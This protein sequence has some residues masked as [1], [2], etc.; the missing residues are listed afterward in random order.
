MRQLL[1]VFALLFVALLFCGCART[2]YDV[3]FDKLDS[4]EAK[5]LRNKRLLTDWDVSELFPG[6]PQ[7]QALATA[8]GKGDVQKI[9]QLIDAGADPNASGVYGQTVPA[10][11]VLHPNEKG[12]RRLL[13]RGADPNRVWVDDSSPVENRCLP[14]S[15]LHYV[16]EYSYRI[17]PEY[18]KMCLE[19]GK[20]DPNLQLPVTGRPIS[21][22]L[23]TDQREAFAV[24]YNAGAQIDYRIDDLTATYSLIQAAA[25]IE[26]YE[27]VLFMLE[28][29]VDY[30]HS[31]NG[32]TKN[33]LDLM[34]SEIHRFSLPRSTNN[35][36]Y[37]YFW[38][39]VDYLEKHGVP[40]D[41]STDYKKCS[42]GGCAPIVRPSVLATTPVDYL[43]KVEDQD[44]W[45]H[46]FQL[47]ELFRF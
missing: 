28:R 35:N 29:G 12:F 33:L 2:E 22:A 46:R 11:L 9:D 3:L 43:K 30:T 1:P 38:R 17:G 31:G 37:M 34:Q 4:S 15:L 18:L 47:K 13:E 44:D 36:Q 39:C 41:I 14:S 5:Y 42:P 26:N 20:G 10:W 8:A 40:F 25:T 27:L 19:I 23:G 16:T 24:L 45:R 21:F 6:N 32:Y 7:A